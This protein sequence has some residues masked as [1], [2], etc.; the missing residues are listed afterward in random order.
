MENIINTALCHTIHKV[1]LDK[2]RHAV[3]WHLGLMT[4]LQRA[5]KRNRSNFPVL[6]DT[7]PCCQF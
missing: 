1:V 4:Y 6:R 2:I 3:P 5:K 7:E